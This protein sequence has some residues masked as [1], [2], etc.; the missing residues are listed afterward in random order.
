[1]YRGP[2]GEMLGQV[3]EHRLVKGRGEWHGIVGH[4]SAVP[5]VTCWAKRGNVGLAQGGLRPWN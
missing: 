5:G 4:R 1:M 3:L 2:S